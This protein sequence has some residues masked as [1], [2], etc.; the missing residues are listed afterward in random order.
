MNISTH[1]LLN[2]AKRVLPSLIG[3]KFTHTDLADYGLS[4][5]TGANMI[6]GGEDFLLP[7]LSVG[8]EAAIGALFSFSGHLHKTVI[9]E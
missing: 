1:T 7:S 9:D 3:V 6:I 5:S 4:C 2:L 8:G